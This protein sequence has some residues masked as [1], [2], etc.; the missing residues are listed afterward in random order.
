MARVGAG[1][2]YRGSRKRLSRISVRGHASSAS[3][4]FLILMLAVLFVIL[5]CLVRRA[6]DQDEPPL[7]GVRIGGHP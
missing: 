7:G 6:L 4:L 3:W 1:R 2:V 5:P